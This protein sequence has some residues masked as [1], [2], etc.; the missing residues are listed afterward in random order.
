MARPRRGGRRG[1]YAPLGGAATDVAAS[2]DG[3]R[4]LRLADNVF[5]IEHED[6]TDEWPHG[7]TGVI[8]GRRACS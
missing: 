7:N 6:A 5:V 2:D 4:M 8:V 3:A 1:P